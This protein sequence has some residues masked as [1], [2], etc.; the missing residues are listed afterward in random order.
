MVKGYGLHRWV[1]LERGGPPGRKKPEREMGYRERG[2]M[3]QEWV[4]LKKK[5]RG[6]IL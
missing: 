6:D 1:G 2:Q 4:L 5:I 3:G